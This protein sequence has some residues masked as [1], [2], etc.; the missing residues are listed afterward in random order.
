M[1][2]HDFSRIK[3]HL[4]QSK[5]LDLPRNYSFTKIDEEPS[6]TVI[7]NILKKLKFYTIITGYKIDLLFKL[8]L[9]SLNV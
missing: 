9:L 1:K 7:D 5:I 8:L 4:N 6:L 2:L 3:P